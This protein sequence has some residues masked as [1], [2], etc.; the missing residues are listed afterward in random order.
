MATGGKDTRSQYITWTRRED[1]V[2]ARKKESIFSVPRNCHESIFG[3][4][5][6]GIQ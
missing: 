4:E 6:K 2:H 1:E 5:Q 3:K